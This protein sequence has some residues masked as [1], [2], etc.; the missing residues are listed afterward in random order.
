MY[1]SHYNLASKPF[2]M[3]TDPGFLWLGEKHKE[4]LA[5]LKYAIVENKGI[6]AMTGDVGTGKT[7]LTNALIQSLGDD[8]LVAIIYDPSLGV[9]EFFNI[10]SFAFNM[11]RTFD[12]KGEFLIYF[13]RFLKKVRAQNKKVL[14]IID[15][16]QR[17]SNEL[18]EEIRLLSNLEDEYVQ[19]LN[20]FFV[21]Q[22]EFIDI[23]KEYKNRGLGQRITLSYHIEPLTLSETESYIRHRLKISGAKARIFSSDAVQ[24]SFSFS[25]GYPR[26]I[27]IICDHALL[28]GY[29][30][31]ILI[32]TADIINECK[33][34]LKISNLKTDQDTYVSDDESESIRKVSVIQQGVGN[35]GD[36][37]ESK[38][39]ISDIQKD[40][41]NSHRDKSESKPGI[42]VI[43]QEESSE[44]RKTPNLMK[45]KRLYKR[46]KRLLKKEK[47]LDKRFSVKLPV[48]LEAITSSRKRVFLA[49]TKDISATGAFIYTKEA[50][51]IPD[52][53]QFIIDSFHPK[54]STI[55]LKRL[56]QLKNCMGTVVRSTSEG[57]A[58]RFNRPIELFV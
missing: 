30:R 27:N 45:E 1:L 48:K 52:D 23:L 13:K 41:D 2:Q 21:G 8:T 55:K 31:E 36:E 37:S 11:G 12:G 17:I 19:L 28:S 26:L 38:R 10:I 56:K 43:Q 39:K 24:E 4:A 25:N 34:D 6:L 5:T 51:Y 20:I 3:S 7:T 47:R 9:L 33:E 14:L 46:I 49:E 42:S 22:N 44:H 40:T 15:E 57:I 50:S 53:S 35:S 32:I 54:K 29:V 16:A 18:L 58:I